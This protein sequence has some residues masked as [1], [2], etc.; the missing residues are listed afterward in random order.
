M[1]HESFLHPFDGKYRNATVLLVIISLAS[2]LYY[3]QLSDRERD[4]DIVPP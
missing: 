4:F 3:R 2:I 1:V